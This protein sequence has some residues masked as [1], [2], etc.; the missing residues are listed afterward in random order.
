[1][2][3]DHQTMTLEE[4][5]RLAGEHYSAERFVE[6]ENIYRQILATYPAQHSIYNI[7]GEISLR[8]GRIAEAEELLTKAVAVDPE[9]VSTLS[10]LA[11]LLTDRGRLEEAIGYCRKA[12]EIDPNTPEA[13]YN[14]ANALREQGK[15]EEAIEHYHKALEINSAFVEAH[16]NLG[17]TYRELGKIH[18]AISQHRK[19]LEI[20][21]DFADAYTDMGHA[22]NILGQS[23]EAQISLEQGF[24][25]NHGGP[26]WNVRTVKEGE[27]NS[28]TSPNTPRFAST[29]KLRDNM[30]QLEYLINTHKIDPSFRSVAERYR[31]VYDE[32]RLQHDREETKKLTSSQL[33]QLGSSYDRVIHLTNAS[34]IS[35]GAVNKNLA[36]EDM[37]ERYFA[38]STPVITVDNLLTT[39]A[40]QELRKFCLESTIYFVC[41]N[42][43]FVISTLRNGFNCD[44]LYQI[45]EE[46]Q[47]HFPTVLGNHYLSNI[48]TYRYN[49]QTEGVAPH[50]D[51]G[52]VTFNFWI[53]PDDSNLVP[54]SG[55]LRIYPKTQ[56]SDWDWDHYNSQ[57]YT[58]TI[59]QEIIEFLANTEAVTVPHRQN[60]AVL[61][62]SNLFHTSEQ[63][64]F[65]DGF[66]SRRI[67]ITML[68]GKYGQ[69]DETKDG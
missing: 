28:N 35:T 15:L 45:A 7:L 26:W 9:S 5:F 40:L 60:R 4:A 18:E 29:F 55:G 41:R 51:E 1:M 63:I 2:T 21:P 24:R 52:A 30:E 36:F 46:L 62:K 3:E 47:Q 31:D 61:F 16:Y 59:R 22:F 39:E 23:I 38:T 10:N 11:K 50:T 54:E 48:W 56:P 65:R 32:F 53:T 34:R 17:I 37:E 69:Q 68:F 12:I 58:P 13:Q 49:N 8:T 25:I 67:N 6:A 33:D 43:N 57:K 42:N 19:V 27:R 66:E 44:L 14:L 20:R 64:K